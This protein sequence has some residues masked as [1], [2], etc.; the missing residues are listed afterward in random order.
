MLNAAKREKKM[1]KSRKSKRR[2]ML[3]QQALAAKAGRGGWAYTE[4]SK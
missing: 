3:L 4:S 1:R 2:Q